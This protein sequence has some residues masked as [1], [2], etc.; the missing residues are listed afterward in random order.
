MRGTLGRPNLGF[1]AA[2][3]LIA[4]GCASMRPY[5][6]GPGRRVAANVPQDSYLSGEPVNVTI[7]NLSEVTLFYPDGFCKTK[8]Q[9]RDATAWMTISDPSVGCPIELGFLE[10]GQTVVHQYRLPRGVS[11][12]TY[13]L[14]IPMPVAEEATAPEPEL[15]TPAFKVQSASSQ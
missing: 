2:F 7:S 6:P 11:V 12:G 15:L 9:R 4:S 3:T 10:P 1:F 13:R 8:L 14:A 5:D